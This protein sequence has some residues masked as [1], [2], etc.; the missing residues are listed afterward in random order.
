MERDSHKKVYDP[1]HGF[2]RFDD[3]EKMLI[4][5]FAFQRL[6]YIH[7]LGGAYLVFPGA[8]HSRFEHSL[9]VMELSSRIYEKIC[10]Y[11]CLAERTKLFRYKHSIKSLCLV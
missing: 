1:I 10:E 7:Q 11:S 6:H 5:S 4:D 3:N 9:G 8:T 2:I